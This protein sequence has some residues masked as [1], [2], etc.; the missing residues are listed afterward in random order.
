MGSGSSK[1]VDRRSIHDII[2]D[3]LLSEAALV[4]RVEHIRRHQFPIEFPADEA[5]PIEYTAFISPGAFQFPQPTG[6]PVN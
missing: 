2:D 4:K 6:M 3:E 5:I 1:P